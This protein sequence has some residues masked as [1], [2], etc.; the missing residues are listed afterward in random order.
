MVVVPAWTLPTREQVLASF[1]GDLCLREDGDDSV[2]P[3]TGTWEILSWPDDKFAS[4][5]DRYKAAGHTLAACSFR[6]RNYHGRDFDLSTDPLL[7]RERLARC[8]RAG[9]IPMPDVE[10]YDEPRRGGKTLERMP[11]FL[12]VL[13][14]HLCALFQV[15]ELRVDGGPSHFEFDESLEWFRIV[16]GV[17]G[18]QPVIGHE[19]LTPADRGDLIIW[20]ARGGHGL[21]EYWTETPASEVDVIL[22]E[23]PGDLLH[24]HKRICMEVGGA[25]CRLSGLFPIADQW[26]DG[27]PILDDVRRNWST[28]LQ[29]GKPCVFFEA[30][31]SQRMYSSQKRLIRQRVRQMIP[32][33]IGHGDG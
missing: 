15:W 7:A 5:A 21:R 9:I 25:V 16:R 6:V 33:L 27:E 24:D 29:I 11:A 17:L 12:D 1:A 30:G 2:Y 20:D 22:L 13:R 23:P 31:S 14:D 32:S 18:P 26:W 8:Y 4:W 10:F 19:L 28:D 3:G